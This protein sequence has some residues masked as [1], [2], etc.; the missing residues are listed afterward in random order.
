MKIAVPY[1]NGQVFQHFGRSE[2]FKIYT[3]ENGLLQ[4][5][6]VIPTNGQGHGA[7]AGFLMQNHVNVVLCGGIGAGAQSALAQAGIQL[8]GGLSGSADAAVTE[9]LAGR[10]DPAPIHLPPTGGSL[11]SQAA[12]VVVAV[13]ILPVAPA[14]ASYG[15]PGRAQPVG[16]HSYR[17]GTAH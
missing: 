11:C 6:E 1:E 8:F 10:L 9:Y 13:R 2:Q 16:R 3:A 4:D 7:L 15:F 17:L 14:A 5:A 12:V